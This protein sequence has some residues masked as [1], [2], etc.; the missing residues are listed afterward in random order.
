MIQYFK[1]FWNDGMQQLLS[2]SFKQKAFLIFCLGLILY[3]P[4]MDNFNTTHDE[5]Y[6]LL[7]FQYSW[8]DMIKTLMAEDGHPPLS[9]IFIRLF[10]SINNEYQIALARFSSVL[11][12]MCTAL[13]GVFPLRRLLGDKVALLY[14]LFVF[15]FPA[16]FHL[17][18]N[19][20]MYPLAVLCTTGAFLYAL[21]IVHK[22]RRS[23]WFWLSFFSIAGLYTHYYCGMILAVIWITL[24]LD[25][26]KTKQ[27]SKIKW[28]FL[29]GTIVAFCFLPWILVFINQYNNMKTDWYPSL[30]TAVKAIVGTVF[31]YRG[32]YNAY[33]ITTFFTIFLGILSWIL[34]F[35]FL[36]ETKKTDLKNIIVKRAATICITVYIMAWLISLIARPML[37]D[38]YLVI[39]V[40]LV[41]IAV[42]MAFI[43]YTQFRKLFLIVFIPALITNWYQ[44][45][46][47]SHEQINKK[48]QTYFH[49]NI[50]TD[51]LI[52]YDFTF[53]HLFLRF[54]LP[55]YSTLYTPIV[56]QL[57]LLDEEIKEEQKNF[58]K[59]E[60]YNN[61]YL[62]SS[63]CNTIN[64]SLFQPQKSMYGF[65]ETLCLK[66]L[67]IDEAQFYIINGKTFYK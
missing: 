31:Y 32:T 47:I 65:Y 39:F 9:Y 50:P 56:H 25:L 19:I 53:S 61:I 37:A 2:L 63:F 11:I 5:K 23:D 59:L 10:A 3:L 49:E 38:V 55:E 43:H 62:L 17:G 45:N 14:M 34:I 36:S 52:L 7:V 35:Q 6:T 22:Y 1:Q 58:K 13:L 8:I 4:L 46:S 20:R 16:S 60:N 48:I 29:N 12:L 27:F 30:Q 42:S 26:I 18:I 33:T 40:G 24:L 64:D 44:Y 57:V 54:Y 28:L 66:K 15:T 67:T 51:S 21:T 41:Y